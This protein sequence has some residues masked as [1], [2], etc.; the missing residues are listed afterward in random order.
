MIPKM[1]MC[2]SIDDLYFNLTQQFEYGYYHRGVKYT[3]NK[4]EKDRF[5]HYEVSTPENFMKHRVGVCFDYAI[6][7][8]L[9]ISK[10]FMPLKDHE[11]TDLKFWYIECVNGTIRP[12]HTWV[13]YRRHGEF[14][15]LEASWYNYRGIHKYDNENDMLKDY[16]DKH[17]ESKDFVIMKIDAKNL[18]KRAVGLNC[19]QFMDY[20]WKIG[21]IVRKQGKIN[22]PEYLSESTSSDFRNVV[23]TI[24]GTILV[25][26]YC[27]NLKV[28]KERGDNI[29]ID[30]RNEIL[31]D[32][33]LIF[34]RLCEVYK[35]V[36]SE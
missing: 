34:R 8:Y 23:Y 3:G 11:I 29:S 16:A 10:Y 6:F 18:D 28:L 1:D 5:E 7:E 4:L 19:T 26:K 15:V 32:N 24:E 17:C 33:N 14:E 31:K 9:Y 12:T 25:H 21:T 22:R 27:K 13:S 36:E 30:E 2:G 35:N 20:M